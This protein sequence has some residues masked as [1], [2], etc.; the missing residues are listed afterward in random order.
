MSKAISRLRSLELL[1][2]DRLDET[3]IDHL[4]GLPTLTTLSLETMLV[5]Y[6]EPPAFASLESLELR[7]HKLSTLTSLLEPI[8]LHLQSVSFVLAET[9]TPHT[10]HLFCTTLAKASHPERLS[11][12]SLTESSENW[13]RREISLFT[14]QPLDVMSNISFDDD[15]IDT[16]SKHRPTLV[17]LSLNKEAG[18]G[19]KPPVTPRSLIMLFFRCAALIVLSLA[20][21]FSEVDRPQISTSRP[22]H[23]VTT[24]CRN[25]NF[26]TSEIH[27]PITIAAF[28][29]DLCTVS[30]TRH[31]Q[32]R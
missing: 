7:S 16:L 19:I 20:V 29:S 12:I 32:V 11:S 24:N 30:Y 6:L 2:C 5:P 13:L 23:G 21:D 28:L 8:E 14:L 27:Y 18:W 17:D 1:V 26:V 25:V 15:P 3:A 10:I 9:P 22:G 31:G 4:S